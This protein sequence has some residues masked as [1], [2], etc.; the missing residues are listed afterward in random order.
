M[1]LADGGHGGSFAPDCSTMYGR[2][3]LEEQHH[4]HEVRLH[5]IINHHGHAL[6]NETSGMCKDYAA[7]RAKNPRWKPDRYHAGILRKNNEAHNH[8]IERSRSVV[9]S[10]LPHH[11]EMA[12]RRMRNKGIAPSAEAVPLTTFTTKH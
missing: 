5:A 10:E 11:I 8:L 1:P 4:D 6:D 9:G 7:Y 3:C 12:W 2:H